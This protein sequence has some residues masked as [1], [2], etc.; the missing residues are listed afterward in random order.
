L[1]HFVAT[2]RKLIFEEEKEMKSRHFFV[3]IFF[4]VVMIIAN[5]A[6]AVVYYDD[7]ESY[8]SN[9][10]MNP[11]ASGLYAEHW[12]SDTSYTTT[13]GAWRIAEDPIQGKFANTY[14]LPD[15]QPNH[16]WLAFTVE[17]P[18]AISASVL[19]FDYLVQTNTDLEIFI[20][21]VDEHT[22]LVSVPFIFEKRANSGQIE[23]NTNSI[24]LTPYLSPDTNRLIVRL[25][26]TTTG[27]S[28]S[29]ISID[30]FSLTVVPE[31]ATL[32]LLGLGGLFLRRRS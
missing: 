29:H 14:G 23:D 20:S 26:A 1:L 4:I 21:S 27:S 13:N 30:N 24:D 19:Q 16:H 8:T 5:N 18:Y 12:Y 6:V 11:P 25:D 22:D 9:G 31:P 3:S 28:Y 17:T 32:L 10:S 7:F 2:E 15:D